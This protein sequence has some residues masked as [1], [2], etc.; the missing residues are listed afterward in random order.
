MIF[1]YN[2]SDYELIVAGCNMSLGE[3][4]ILKHFVNLLLIL[5]S[6][7]LNC[8]NE[9]VAYMTNENRNNNGEFDCYQLVKRI[10]LN[11]S[12]KTQYIDL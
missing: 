1:G 6:V 12:L 3:L 11:W 7:L 4:I 5:L 9:T 10:M 8:C 2:N